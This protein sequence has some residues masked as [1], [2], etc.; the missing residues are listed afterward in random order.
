M[1]TLTKI[2][3]RCHIKTAAE[4][5]YRTVTLNDN[6]VPDVKGKDFNEYWIQN[7]QPIQVNLD[8]YMFPG[9]K[10][11]IRVQQF[12]IIQSDARVIA[13]D[14][15]WENLQKTIIEY[16]IKTL[17]PFNN[18]DSD[19]IY[20]F[21]MIFHAKD[22]NIVEEE[23]SDPDQSSLYVNVELLKIT[24]FQQLQTTAKKFSCALFK[25]LQT[26]LKFKNLSPFNCL[27]DFVITVILVEA[28]IPNYNVVINLAPDMK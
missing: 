17:L 22:S 7:R 19:A 2:T 12:K 26:Y 6:L 23:G 14:T 5:K 9:D 1:A 18:N 25:Q 16:T 10:I 3:P 24:N 20:P 21:N 15:F 11:Y 4:D 8:Q 28:L 27:L 13:S